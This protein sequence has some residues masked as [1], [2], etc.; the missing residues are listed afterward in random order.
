M[1]DCIFCKIINKEIPS[2]VVYEDDNF[3]AFND[4]H[5]KAK[6]H[7]LIVPR[8]HVD[9]V[10]TLE[11]SDRDLAGDI[12]LTAKKVAELLGLEGYQLKFH[13]G[14]KGGQEVFHIHLHLLAG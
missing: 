10:M 11:K 3:V 9:S 12:I 13:V 5:P 14:T 6:T 4:I 8:R 1:S 7:V 2:T